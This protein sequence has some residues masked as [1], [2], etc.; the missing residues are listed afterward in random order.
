MKRLNLRLAL[1]LG[2]TA[3]V[4]VV[5]TIFL[6]E[7]QVRRN[8]GKLLAESK[9][10][11]EKGE[12]NRAEQA[13]K[14]YVNYN[15]EDIDAQ[16]EMLEIQKELFK[17]DRR[18]TAKAL[19]DTY[20]KLLASRPDDA[21]LRRDYM[22]FCLD[23][24]NFPVAMQQIVELRNL[25]KLTA[26]DEYYEARLLASKS[27][28][29]AIEILVKLVGFDQETKKFNEEVSKN[30]K[31]YLAYGLLAALYQQ[32][33]STIE[34]APL[35]IE[36]LLAR[37]PDEL[38]SQ[39]IA[40]DFWSRRGQQEKAR[41]ALAKAVQL[42]PDSLEVLHMQFNQFYY[43]QDFDAALKIAEQME[44]SASAEKV[45]PNELQAYINL[46]KAYEAKKEREKALASLDR[47]LARLGNQAPLLVEKLKLFL[48]TGAKELANSRAIYTMLA[49]SQ[50]PAEKLALFEGQI[51]FQEKKYSE[52]LDKLQAANK[53][54]SDPLDK[55]PA[56]LALAEC[57]KALGSNDLARSIYVKLLTAYPQLHE[58][59]FEL[60]NLMLQ[61]G[62]VQEAQRELEY[63]NKMLPADTMLAQPQRWQPL[64][65]TRIA[66]QMAKPADKRDW[67]SVDD[68][69]AKLIAQPAEVFPELDKTL[70]Q[71]HVRARQGDLD[72]ALA[73]ILPLR[74]QHPEDAK[75]W[76]EWSRLEMQRGKPKELLQ[77][78]AKA[79]VAVQNDPR[80]L[81]LQAEEWVAIGGDEGKAGL[82]EI[83]NQSAGQEQEVR[84]SLH[85]IVSQAFYRMGQQAEAE[86]VANLAVP[87]A[88]GIKPRDYRPQQLLLAYAQE[89]GD[90]PAMEK[91]YEQIRQTSAPDSDNQLYAQSL[92]ILTKL[93]ES[94]KKKTNT[95][96]AK[97]ILDPAEEKL[98]Q[99]AQ[100]LADKLLEKRSDWIE[101]YKLLAD[102][103]R[104][105][106]NQPAML[107]AL[108]TARTK[109]ELEPPRL[110]QLAT[111]LYQAGQFKESSAII[112]QLSRR[113]DISLVK[114]KFQLLLQEG[115]KSEA[116]TLL[117]E[118]VLPEQA[119]PAERL[120]LAQ[121][122]RQLGQLE[123]SEATVRAMVDRD[124]KL[125][126]P[127]AWFLLANILRE[128]K[129][130]FESHELLD[131]V[132]RLP[133]SEMQQILAA[134]VAETIGELETALQMFPQL[135][136]QYPES[137]VARR[138]LASFYMR[139]KMNQLALSTIDQLNQL[140]EK[141]PKAPLA[142]EIRAWANRARVVTDVK[143]GT[144][145]YEEFVNLDNLLKKSIEERPYDISD[146][147]LR[148]SLL[149]ERQEAESLRKAIEL[150]LELDRRQPLHV[151]DQLVLAKLYSRVGEWSKGR[152]LIE[153]LALKQGADPKLL[154]NF[155]E[156]LVQNE[157]YGTAQR[158][159]E[160]YISQTKDRQ[161]FLPLLATIYEKLGDKKKSAEVL[162][163]WL[164]KRPVLRENLE[165]LELAAKT[166]EK[167]GNLDA[168]EELYREY[169]E[170]GLQG[171]VELARFLGENR[172]LN[173]GLDML[174]GLFE[175]SGA[176]VG[177]I[178][179]ALVHYGAELIRTS[180][181]DVTKEQ[182]D[183]AF[184]R[185]AVW[186]QAYKATS[187]APEQLNGLLA[188]IRVLQDN[189]AGA[190]QVYRD[191]IE[192]AKD[193]NTMHVAGL[194]N[195]LAY[196]LALTG[197][198]AAYTEAFEAIEQAV[199]TIGPQSDLLDTRGLLYI[200]MGDFAKAERDL[201]D[202]ALS[203]DAIK[204]FRLAYAQFKLGK[205][206]L[207][208]V[209][210]RKAREQGLKQRELSPPEKV[211]YEEMRK[212]LG[213]E[214]F[215]NSSSEAVAQRQFVVHAI[216]PLFLAHF[217]R[218]KSYSKR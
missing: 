82:L 10:L 102:I 81:L 132:R 178:A 49:G 36:E 112:D 87:I 198:N 39:K 23:I 69:V 98:L 209:S 104:Y 97:V 183:E 8:A 181:P 184:K 54:L 1:I 79:P 141:N 34:L 206:D 120:W 3:I 115:K 41:Q 213:D 70:L 43:T 149:A 121:A 200:Q 29:K 57:Y 21:Q 199:R 164:G 174:Q 151:A 185:L 160:S 6:H 33:P 88:E 143:T 78:L 179:P 18:N 167:L 40:I 157:E 142:A 96:S 66:E 156:L 168:A 201:A 113:G 169:A 212:A 129:K 207:A 197:N 61:A 191:T 91:I 19:A 45:D 9:K 27:P 103:A 146:L 94:Q 217:N 90:I 60:A 158:Y 5:G 118:L 130:A 147:V 4:C 28:E 204:L 128:E 173:T 83:L 111:M 67:K 162:R 100:A 76:F 12:Y 30:C 117:N 77:Q 101:T 107:E 25:R 59:R 194:R 208:K 195:N 16:E 44:K 215:A 17:N 171:Q 2:V 95:N 92:L 51:L 31:Q 99:E 14:R 20:V 134:R 65:N 123:S 11:K 196:V 163:E 177:Q 32:E 119:A 189:Y 64:L 105:R 7:M 75:I 108:K 116:E 106:N 153:A 42:A 193:K 38:D 74:E 22:K 63:L 192:L 46:A 80:L 58:V 72:G 140:L 56:E 210:I 110:R 84:L 48:Q 161:T 170:S 188:E 155:A 165:K 148:I 152:P 93:R 180:G 216:K 182:K 187:P 24:Q 127:D 150:L 190:A 26:E 205:N 175:K 37:H 124:S 126:I 55:I 52:A 114:L 211:Y 166:L 47:G 62:K 71:T 125:E 53:R 214:T 86:K 176:Q 68:L 50:L 144:K 89:R 137:I 139:Q 35:V 159:L 135:V 73:M 203:P 172:G 133:Q 145:S 122:Q 131:R 138:E 136:Q 154:V 85:M 15:P 218:S 13:L 202:A 109:G 186:F